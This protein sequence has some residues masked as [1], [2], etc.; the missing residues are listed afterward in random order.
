MLNFLRT[1]TLLILAIMLSNGAHAQNKVIKPLK[2]V[3]PKSSNPYAIPD[4]KSP[5]IVKKPI[6]AHALPANNNVAPELAIQNIQV[7][8]IERDDHA[9][10]DRGDRAN[11]PIKRYTVNYSYDL[12]NNSNDP[13]QA[14]LVNGSTYTLGRLKA[15]IRTV[16][17]HEILSSSQPHPAYV[18]TLRPADAPPSVTPG[19]SI[20]MED[21]TTVSV[22]LNANEALNPPFNGINVNLP[23]DVDYELC[24][25]F[26]RNQDIDPANE[27]CHAFNLHILQADLSLAGGSVSRV[28][29][30]G[31]PAAPARIR[32]QGITY[33]VANSGPDSVAAVRGLELFPEIISSDSGISLEMA[34]N[35]VCRPVDRLANGESRV[36]NDCSGGVLVSR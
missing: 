33:T 8:L 32:L 19:L 5:I 26:T 14:E 10:I 12:I 6:P 34:G 7:A 15:A 20:A 1:L 3:V 13:I 23:E 25:N 36:F 11:I 2:P 4:K 31:D 24:L 21:D 29:L 17:N 30:I 9:F 18:S 28:D 35:T 22:Y 16:G 27:V